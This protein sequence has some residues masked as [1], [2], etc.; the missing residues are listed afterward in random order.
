MATVRQKP[1]R[2]AAPAPAPAQERYGHLDWGH[3]RFFLELVRTGSHGRAA[4]RMGVDR[5][6]VARR[7]AALEAELG[8]ALFERGPQGWSQTLEGQEL[9]EL[10]SRVEEHV[11]ALARH[12]DARDPTLRGMARLTTVPHLATHLLPP[13]LPALRQRHP[14]LVLEVVA[15]ARAFDLSRREADLA[16]RLGRPHDSGL[17]ARRLSQ[18]AHGFY[19]A[20][21]T[22][23]GDRGAVDFRA[24]IFLG[25][26]GGASEP[27]ERWL[28]ELA[29]ER[30][31]VY[32]C[33]STTSLLEVARQGLGVVLLPCY[34]GDADPALRRLD[35]PEP[36]LHEIWLLVHGDL[37]R[38]PRV[39][40]VMDWLDELV[41]RA[42]PAL[43]G[44]R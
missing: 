28:Q 17:V 13:A 23:A 39:R 12:V 2:S 38:T 31:V 41:A 6:T 44:Q 34:I 26:E 7:V 25:G 15:D 43:L 36:A 8:V 16:M 21:A 24:D 35:G 4:K 29:P 18:L 33:N 1:Q 37:R 20:A 5:N 11:M 9:A 32:R 19:A 3:L 22:A 27:Q 42:R 30:R 14:E 10:A 40:A